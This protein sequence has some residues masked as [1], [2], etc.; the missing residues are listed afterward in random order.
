MMCKYKKAV[1]L[2]GEPHDAAVNFDTHRSL[3]RYRAV[4]CAIARLSYQK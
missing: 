3:K 1:L 2:Q 4:S